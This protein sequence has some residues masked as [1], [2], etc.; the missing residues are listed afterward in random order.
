M[1]TDLRRSV[2]L[3]VGAGYAQSESGAWSIEVEPEL[4]LRPTSAIRIGFEPGWTRARSMAF[5]VTQRQDVTATTTYGGRYLFAQLDQTEVDLT[6]R[7]DIALSPRLSVQ[8]WAQPYIASGDYAGFKELARPA[9]FDFL[10]YGIDSGSTIS[11]DE[12][13]NRYTVDPDGDGEAPPITFENPDFLFRSLR[14]NLVLRWEYVR[15]STLF[16]VWNHGRGGGSTEP[17]FQLGEQLG[18]LWDDDG[19]NTFLVKVNYWLSR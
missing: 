3:A 17:S 16:V 9:S 11:F 14:S 10:R 8:L 15:G 7:M 2:A 12:E 19:Q 5:Y 18:N 1:G 4:Q 13:T 6:V